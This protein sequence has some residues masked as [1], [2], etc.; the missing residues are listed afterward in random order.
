MKMKIVTM[1]HKEENW[2]FAICRRVI[3]T[4]NEIVDED[5]SLIIVE[6][7]GIG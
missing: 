3:F 6:L 5:D 7:R 2:N 4:L 1:I